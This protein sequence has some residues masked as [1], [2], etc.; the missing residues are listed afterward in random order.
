MGETDT[1]EPGKSPSESDVLILS[2]EQKG[3]HDVEA[4]LE[5]AGSDERLNAGGIDYDTD[6]DVPGYHPD[7]NE[8]VVSLMDLAVGRGLETDDRIRNGE[9]LIDNRLTVQG[10]ADFDEVEDVVFRLDDWEKDGYNAK[11]E[12]T[13][14]LRSGDRT[15][16]WGRY[17]ETSMYLEDFE[18]LV[19][20]ADDPAWAG[21]ARPD[22]FTVS[23]GELQESIEKRRNWKDDLELDDSE[24]LSFPV[25]ASKARENSGFSGDHN[26]LHHHPEAAESMIEHYPAIAREPEHERDFVLAQGQSIPD[27]YS[28]QFEEPLTDIGVSLHEMVYAIAEEEETYAPF[29]P[30]ATFLDASGAATRQMAK[31]TDDF[32]SGNPVGATLKAQMVPAAFFQGL[33]SRSNRS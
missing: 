6:G 32:Y 8:Y 15:E 5:P 11:T 18:T 24:E 2:E 20:D 25:T 17:R 22:S 26:I 1:K 33:A 30:V 19:A 29:N 12:Y 7:H 31:A 23:S 4:L 10:P 16:E 21:D 13:I 9:L 14:D 27:A 28:H 3:K